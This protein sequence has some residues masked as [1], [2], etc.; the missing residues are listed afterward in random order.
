MLSQSGSFWAQ[1][2]QKK[3]KKR[4][5][6]K[7]QQKKHLALLQVGLSWYL[8]TCSNSSPD[9]SIS[10]KL[11]LRH[12]VYKTRDNIN[13]SESL[14]S[15][16]SK[17]AICYNVCAFTSLS[18]KVAQVHGMPS[19]SPAFF[20]YAVPSVE[21]KLLKKYWSVYLNTSGTRLTAWR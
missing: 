9:L 4:V 7:R 3:R 15:A 8:P 1:E 17:V 18:C 19:V 10:K 16:G 2:T 12:Q 6:N 21:L 20:A 5:K 14:I 11:H 13:H